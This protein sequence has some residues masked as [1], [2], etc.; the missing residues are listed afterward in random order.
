MPLFWGIKLIISNQYHNIGRQELGYDQAHFYLSTT[1][2][3][4]VHTAFFSS[5]LI[6]TILAIGHWFHWHLSFNS[7]ISPTVKFGVC[8]CHFCLGCRL[9][10]NSFLHLLRRL[11]RRLL[12]YIGVG[13]FASLRVS[14]VRGLEFT[15]NSTLVI[16]VLRDLSFKDELWVCR[17]HCLDM[18]LPNTTHMWFCWWIMVPVNL[19]CSIFLRQQVLDFIMI[20]FFES[21]LQFI[22]CSHKICTIVWPDGSNSTSSCHEPSKC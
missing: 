2:I 6:L 10:R 8:F 5:V 18:M 14:T 13:L 9:W 11:M 20:H 19:I 16:K 22:P 17:S 15:I 3:V 7:I 12:G 1:W 21:L 4:T